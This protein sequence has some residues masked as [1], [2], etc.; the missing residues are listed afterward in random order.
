MSGCRTAAESTA[1]GG[2]RD[3]GI[4]RN[5]HQRGPGRA[6]SEVLSPPCHSATPF[7]PANVHSLKRVDQYCVCP[8]S[9]LLGSPASLCCPI[10]RGTPTTFREE[11]RCAT[12]GWLRVNTF[13]RKMSPV[14]RVL[15][16]LR[17]FLTLRLSGVCTAALA[18]LLRSPASISSSTKWGWE[19]ASH[20]I[21]CAFWFFLAFLTG[22]KSKFFVQLFWGLISWGLVVWF[23]GGEG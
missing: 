17:V 1:G 20:N 12:L 3:F 9:P 16:K 15:V 14:L 6:R 8:Q 4:L 23:F 22:M 7:I 13:P 2:R 19:F 11:S 5:L 18:K 10:P 21:F